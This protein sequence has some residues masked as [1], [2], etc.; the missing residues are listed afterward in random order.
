MRVLRP[1]TTFPVGGSG[2][3]LSMR[4]RAVQLYFHWPNSGQFQLGEK[5]CPR[6][7]TGENFGK[8]AARHD[9]LQVYCRS[10]HSDKRKECLI[11]RRT[12]K[13]V[14]LVG[15]AGD[16]PKKW[17]EILRNEHLGTERGASRLTYGY[18]EQ[19]TW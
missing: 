2:L 3:K 15:Q 12:K 13:T 8:N 11:N 14:S 4:G 7:G 5:R 1:N 18:D 9:G 10:C 6:C 19:S 17:E 16:D